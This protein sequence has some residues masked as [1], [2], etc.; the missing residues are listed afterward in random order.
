MLRSKSYV[1]VTSLGRSR[2]V[3]S[4]WFGHTRILLTTVPEVREHRPHFKRTMG[5]KKITSEDVFSSSHLPPSATQLQSQV[6]RTA[7]LEKC[8]ELSTI[9]Q[10]TYFLPLPNMCILLGKVK[11]RDG[12]DWRPGCPQESYLLIQ[13]DIVVWNT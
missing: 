13:Y 7:S 5:N 9:R 4:P 12:K 11:I 10:I 8:Q 2:F 3:T 6:Y 1:P